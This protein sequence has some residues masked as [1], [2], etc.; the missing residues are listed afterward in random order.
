MKAKSGKKKLKK[1]N[2]G[3]EVEKR[4]KLKKHNKAN[5]DEGEEQGQA[6]EIQQSK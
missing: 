4:E 3:N 2:K 1:Y 6:K 5:E